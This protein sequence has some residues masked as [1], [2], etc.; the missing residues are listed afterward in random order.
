[1]VDS[2][3]PRNEQMKG[4]WKQFK[5]KIRQAW[6]DITDDELDK[7]QGKREQLVGRLMERSGKQRAEIEKRVDD[8][9]RETEYRF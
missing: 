6:G 8:I 5:G 9:S 2:D 3:S 4:N 1:M 7:L